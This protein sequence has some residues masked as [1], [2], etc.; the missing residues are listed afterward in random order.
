MLQDT[1]DYKSLERRQ[2]AAETMNSGFRRGSGLSIQQYPSSDPMPKCMCERQAHAPASCQCPSQHFKLPARLFHNTSLQRS[3]YTLDCL[4]FRSALIPS[5]S[6]CSSSQIY[7][8]SIA[9]LSS[10]RHSSSSYYG[11][12]VQ[13]LHCFH[14]LVL[15]SPI[16]SLPFL[17][18]DISA[19]HHRLIVSSRPPRH[20][21]YLP[22]PFPARPRKLPSVL[23]DRS[24]VCK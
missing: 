1:S 4:L 12:I 15:S 10:F 3:Q 9:W 24:Q 20:L 14:I 21:T 16:S 6:S 23:P 13:S 19:L 18:L 22:H 7:S 2:R 11:L 8:L 17:L 5:L